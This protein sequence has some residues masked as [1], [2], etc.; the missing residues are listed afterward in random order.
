MTLLINDEK[1]II[2][3]YSPKS[4][5]TVICKMF[6]EY[7]N[8][9]ET[10]IKYSSW[11]HNYEQQIYNP[12]QYIKNN[13]P[14]IKI[15][16]IRNPYDR[17]V[18]GYLH[19]MSTKIYDI[20]PKQYR[21]MSFL[22]FLKSYHALK[23]ITYADHFTPQFQKHGI[24]FFNE[25]IKIENLHN[26][27]ERINKKYNLQLNSKFSSKHWKLKK[28]NNKLIENYGIKK[29]NEVKKDIDNNSLPIYKSFYNKEI[30]QLVDKIYH[31]DI[32]LYFK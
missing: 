23:N 21:N 20:L 16:F 12:K 14:Y 2:F 15:K 18:S 6:F 8:L 4:N 28:S 10:A 30:Q 22:D 31:K 17:V 3:E 1:K 9:L 32:Y 24:D 7:I 11:I 25:V 29:W 26:E 19:V 13:I 27:V 5:C